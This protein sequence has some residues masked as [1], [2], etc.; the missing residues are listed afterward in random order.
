V[1]VPEWMQKAEEQENRPVRTVELPISLTSVKLVVPLPDPE[2]GTT[3]DV[4]VKRVVNGNIFHDRH[5]D[6]KTWTRFIAGLNIVIPWPKI[7]PKEH[8]DYDCDTLR[9]DVETKTFVPTLL[10]PPMPSTVID[11]LRNKYSKFRTRHD[12]EYI[13]AK[14]QE[15][16]E[17]EAQK[18]LAKE[19]MTPLKE[20]RKEER[21]LL[22]AK[23]KPKLTEEMLGK[24]GEVMARNR[25]LS[26]PAAEAPVEQTL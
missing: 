8:K 23:G 11:E 9:V 17:K 21:K 1:A 6:R 20:K 26:L 14:I 13:Q 10:K 18:R 22:K 5:T 4:I 16:E 25:P 15:D 7:E 3:R 24:I 2:T 19:M 12:E